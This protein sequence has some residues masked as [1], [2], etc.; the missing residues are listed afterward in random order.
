MLC[1]AVLDITAQCCITGFCLLGNHKQLQVAR[2]PGFWMR[3]AHLS[4]QSHQTGVFAR[5]CQDRTSKIS[6][7]AGVKIHKLFEIFAY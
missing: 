5:F 7:L 4:W 3:K 6:I 2:S 1:C